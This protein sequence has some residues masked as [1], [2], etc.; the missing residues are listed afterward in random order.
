MVNAAGAQGMIP[1]Q[2][3][4]TVNNVK[5]LINAIVN[6]KDQMADALKDLAQE[7]KAPSTAKELGQKSDTGTSGNVQENQH[8]P[9]TFLPGDVPAD[10][11]EAAAAFA[12]AVQ[13][14][15][16]VEK[17]RKKKKFEE[18]LEMLA[19]LEGQFD[20]SQLTNEE[21][22]VVEQFFQ[23]LSVI[24]RFKGQ[25]KFLEDQEIY[26]QGLLERKKAR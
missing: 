8:V 18:K 10:A 13:G 9:G 23:N 15:N 2:Q 14:D 21:Q 11:N 22:E 4:Q 3:T 16:E 25:L 6:S 17:K 1:N 20:L 26:Y 19:K 12:S 7:M 5:D 24:K